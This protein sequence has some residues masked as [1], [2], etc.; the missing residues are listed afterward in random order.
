MDA[1]IIDF[2]LNKIV[3]HLNSLMLMEN[4]FKMGVQTPEKLCCGEKILCIY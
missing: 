4:Y 1:A 3:L 2:F